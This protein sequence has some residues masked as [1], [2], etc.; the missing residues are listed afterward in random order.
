MAKSFLKFRQEVLNKAFDI[1]KAYGAQCWDG[2]MFYSLYWGYP[3]F[4][5]TKT[6]YAQDIWNLRKSSGILNYYREKTTPKVGDIV[7]FGKSKETLDSHI[8][9]VSNVGSKK[10]LVLGQNQGGKVGAFN[11]IYLSRCY[12]LGYLRPIALS[13]D[14]VNSQKCNFIPEGFVRSKGTF[15]V[16]ADKLTIYNAPN[17]TNATSAGLYYL[18]GDYVNYDGYIHNDGFRFISWVSLSTGK[19]RWLKAGKCNDKGFITK[20]YGNM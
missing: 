11:E 12:A 7:I 15:V 8:G 18:K 10:L 16:K 5:C 6:G 14:S 19:R 9:I 13:N 1:D 4:N 3:V 20:P 2:A 17:A